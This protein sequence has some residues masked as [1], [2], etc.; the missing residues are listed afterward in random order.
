MA[1]WANRRAAVLATGRFQ[2][3]VLKGRCRLVLL[4]RHSRTVSVDQE[5]VVVVAFLGRRRDFVLIAFWLRSFL[6]SFWLF[7]A[8]KNAHKRIKHTSS[9]QEI[10]FVYRLHKPLFRQRIE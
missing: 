10:M 4:T 2:F 3:R 9:T 5:G 8:R 1:L 6:A 7:L